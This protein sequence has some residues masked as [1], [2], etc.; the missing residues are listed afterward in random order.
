MSWYTD[1][2]KPPWAPPAWAFGVVWPILY[3]IYA[4]LGVLILW[5]ARDDM[6]LVLLYIAGWAINLLW[7]P[8]FRESVSIWS[9]LWII[10]LLAFTLAL[11]FRLR[12]TIGGLWWC[13]LIPYVAWLAFASSVGFGIAYLN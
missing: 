10:L 2:H 9:P 7:I 13:L 3:T 4:G 6:I 11:L 12:Q 8:L 5:K 1:I